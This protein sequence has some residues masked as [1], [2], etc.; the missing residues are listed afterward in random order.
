ME[1]HEQSGTLPGP[2]GLSNTTATN[3]RP[4]PKHVSLL[5]LSISQIAL[6]GP[7]STSSQHFSLVLSKAGSI[8]FLELAGLRH[9]KTRTI[10]QMCCTQRTVW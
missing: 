9:R 8:F 5:Q 2:R 10:S 3:Y 1:K 6:L 4:A 7:F